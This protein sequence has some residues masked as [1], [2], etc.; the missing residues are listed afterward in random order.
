MVHVS[1]IDGMTDQELIDL[2]DSGCKELFLGVE[3]GSLRII[4]FINKKHTP[5]KVKNA[6]RRLTKTG[7][8]VKCYFIYGF[9]NESIADQQLTLRLARELYYISLSYAG[10]FR[11]SAFKY[12]PYH[13]TWLYEHL[14]KQGVDINFKSDYEL[15]KDI[16]REQF[17]IT[18]TIHSKP[19]TASINKFI[20]QTLELNSNEELLR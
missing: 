2:R 14:Q 7:I 3:S 13:G 20:K 1:I 6:V 12:R 17:N 8:N 4:K 11:T 15:T 5:S 10:R 16:G 19:Q 18:S 9:P